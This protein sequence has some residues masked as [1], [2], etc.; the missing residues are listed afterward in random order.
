MSQTFVLARDAPAAEYAR[1]LAWA[2]LLLAAGGLVM[3]YS[4]SIATAEA[5]R[6][7]G[8][9]AAWFL[10]RHAIFLTAALGAALTV[11]LVPARWWQHAAPWLFLGGVALLAAVLI[12]GIGRE[13]NGARRWLALPV[14]SIQPSELVKLAAVLYAADYTAPKHSHTKTFKR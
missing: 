13:V 3:V 14:V 5:N 11:F 9:N 6:Y 4:A 12:P 10:A 2:A 1:S 7:T 8:N